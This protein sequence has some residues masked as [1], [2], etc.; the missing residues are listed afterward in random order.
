MS[1]EIAKIILPQ[2]MTDKQLID[3]LLDT[4]KEDVFSCQLNP[5]NTLFEVLIKQS[6]NR[7]LLEE[8]LS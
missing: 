1:R 8:Y 3:E 5:L 6:N 7:D 4:V 2:E